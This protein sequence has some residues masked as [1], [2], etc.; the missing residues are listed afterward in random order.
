LQSIITASRAFAKKFTE[1]KFNSGLKEIGNIKPMIS[2]SWAP[3]R[4]SP[5]KT[6]FEKIFLKK[7]VEVR[8]FERRYL[9]RTK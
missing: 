7:P 4:K 9:A 5:E 1:T 2:H 8:C 6:F 3:V